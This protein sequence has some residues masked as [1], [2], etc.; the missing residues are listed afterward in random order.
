MAKQYSVSFFSTPPKTNKSELAY[1]VERQ[2]EKKEEA[3]KR[4]TLCH[5]QG[6]QMKGR[7]REWCMVATPRW[8]LG[9]KRGIFADEF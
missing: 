2:K 8:K 9:E 5:V 1:I 4:S 3:A 6:I 7:L